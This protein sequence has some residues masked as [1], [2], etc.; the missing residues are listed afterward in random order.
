M[1]AKLHVQGL[2]LGHC[3]LLEAFYHAREVPVVVPPPQ[4]PALAKHYE[5]CNN[6]QHQVQKLYASP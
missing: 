2:P 5:A 1:L 6:N 4:G 3:Q